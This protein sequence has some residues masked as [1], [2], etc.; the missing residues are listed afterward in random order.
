MRPH[1][2]PTVLSVAVLLGSHAALVSAQI[3]PFSTA[4]RYTAQIVFA[5]GPAAEPALHVDDFRIDDTAVSRRGAQRLTLRGDRGSFE[6][7]FTG[8]RQIEL[9]RFLGLYDGFAEYDARVTLSDPDG[10][11]RAG[12]LRVRA[13][14]GVANGAPWYLLPAARFD[15]GAG[16]TKITITGRTQPAAAPAPPPAPPKPPQ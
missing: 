16:L 15:R 6:L 2:T 10:V 3:D 14:Q 5:G 4:V 11:V 1:G 13:L 9:Q 12:R 8:V 7:P